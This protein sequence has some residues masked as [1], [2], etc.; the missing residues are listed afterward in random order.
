M[1]LIF[2]CFRPYTSSYFN[3]WVFFPLRILSDSSTP[4]VLRP[5]LMTVVHIPE[6]SGESY[7]LLFPS[8]ILPANL[9]R[10]HTIWSCFHML[11]LV[12]RHPGT[13]YEDDSLRPGRMASK[14]QVI[15]HTGAGGDQCLVNCLFM[16]VAFRKCHFKG[17]SL[18]WENGINYMWQHKDDVIRKRKRRLI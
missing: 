18:D 14:S 5:R 1:N 7:P 12:E 13:L 9:Q 16:I 11:T 6:R 8:S 15:R 3:Q 4:A 2:I 10:R 17:T